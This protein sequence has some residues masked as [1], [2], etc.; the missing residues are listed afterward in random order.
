MQIH[1]LKRTTKLAKNQ[2]IGRGGKRGTTSGRGTKGQMA[3]SGHKLY[4]E[5]RDAI[6]K[7]PKLRGYRFKSFQTKAA[8]VN[9]RA[10]ETAFSAGAIVTPAELVAKKLVRTASGKIPAIKILAT[11]NLTKKLSF[12]GMTISAS[13]KEKIEKAGGEIK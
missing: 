7:L 12:S 9:L 3:R 8:P 5:L 4:P 13:A 1:Q 10:I 6:K 11:G 2:R